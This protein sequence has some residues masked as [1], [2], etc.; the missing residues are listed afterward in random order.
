MH[1]L[2]A[3][4]ALGD[5]LRAKRER[6]QPA[7]FGLPAGRRRRT[8]G[9]R[10][11]EVAQLCGISPTWIAWIEQGR[12]GAVSVAS[13]AAIARG[14]R[15]SQAERRY[16]FELAARRDPRPASGARVPLAQLQPL[17]DCV[18]SP[19]YLLDR[20]WTPLAW[21]RDAARLFSGWLARRADGSPVS[22]LLEYV[23]LDPGARRLIAGWPARSRRL[24]AEY[25]ADTATWL[26]DPVRV[27]LV[28]QLGEASTEFRAAWAQGEVLG[29]EGGERVFLTPAGRRT[30]RQYTLRPALW[31]DLKLVM[32]ARES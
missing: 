17:V 4:D 12:T 31:P 29:R 7:D 1:A 27:E 19:A 32:L 22:S 11:E 2:N 25:R 5:F 20:H 13:L 8:P 18:R 21:N 24:V 10:R 30:F 26:D 15:L 9:L 28:R 23:F 3:P 6:L 16:L 14:L